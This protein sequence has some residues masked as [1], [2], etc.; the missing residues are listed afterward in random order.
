MTAA[1]GSPARGPNG[2]ESFSVEIVVNGQKRQ[3]AERATV[4][5][6]LEQ[7]ELTGR[8]VAVEVNR[9]IVPRSQHADCRLQQGDQLEVV[10]LVGGG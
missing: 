9:Q 3:V 6:L 5:W 2:W 10:T 8:G 4:A 7:L 1:A